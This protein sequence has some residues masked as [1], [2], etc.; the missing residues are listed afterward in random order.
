MGFSSC[1]P[2]KLAHG[3]AVR[4]SP[5]HRSFARALPPVMRSACDVVLE[6]QIDGLEE[7]GIRQANAAREPEPKAGLGHAE[8]LAKLRIT[9]RDLGGALE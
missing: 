4:S 2:Y 3:E 7:D 5:A 1:L 6:H 9:A 8:V